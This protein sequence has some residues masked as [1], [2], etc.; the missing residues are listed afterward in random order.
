[1]ARWSS[2]SLTPRLPPWAGILRMPLMA[3]SVSAVRPCAARLAQ[4]LASPILGAPSLPETWHA[5]Q[6]AS[7]TSL[8]CRPLRWAASAAPLS[9]DS[10]T[11]RTIAGS[12]AQ[13]GTDP[14]CKAI[15][16]PG[17]R[18]APVEPRLLTCPA[19]GLTCV[20][21]SSLASKG[22][23]EHQNR[24]GDERDPADGKQHRPGEKPAEA[25]DVNHRMGG[26]CVEIDGRAIASGRG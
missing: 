6:T 7:T 10:V 19:G 11:K 12:G 8:P 23:L 17:R 3:W 22:A 20:N 5:P 14:D 4:A 15:T 26:T 9:A 18:G 25:A 24:V 13:M 1:M 21:Q 16:T 2:T